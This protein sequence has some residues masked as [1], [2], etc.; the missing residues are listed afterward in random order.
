MKRLYWSGYSKKERIYAISE[1][2]EIVDRYGFIMDFKQFSDL[3]L[4]LSIEVAVSKIEALYE[5]LSKC[6]SLGTWENN[7][8]PQ[9]DECLI[10]LNITFPGTG[11]LTTVV[12]SVPG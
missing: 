3:T 12:P 6:L 11:K 9:E 10:F 8:D 5:D 1:I 4:M 2:Q 7:N